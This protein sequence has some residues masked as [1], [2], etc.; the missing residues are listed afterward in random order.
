MGLQKSCIAE[1]QVTPLQSRQARASLQIGVRELAKMAKV[2]VSTVVR[3]EAGEELK[4]RT[5][6]ALRDTLEKAGV[7]FIGKRGVRLRVPK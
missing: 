2:S 5:V 1:L 3:F 6:D 7:E 4:E